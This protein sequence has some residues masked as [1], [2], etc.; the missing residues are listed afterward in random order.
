MIEMLRCTLCSPTLW[1]SR[2][3]AQQAHRRMSAPPGSDAAFRQPSLAASQD[4]LT[5][6]QEALLRATRAN[7]GAP[8]CE[9][10]RCEFS[11]CEFLRALCTRERAPE[12]TFISALGC[13]ASD[14]CGLI[15]SVFLARIPV[16]A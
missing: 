15:P 13:L 12:S 10:S 14:C 11:S 3:H 6:Q 4:L 5:Q 16:A 1:F 2:S 7:E 8:P 9:I